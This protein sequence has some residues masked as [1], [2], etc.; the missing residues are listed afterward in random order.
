MIRFLLAGNKPKKGDRNKEAFLKGGIPFLH[1]NKLLSDG[2]VK[3]I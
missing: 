1:G 3:Y 2:I